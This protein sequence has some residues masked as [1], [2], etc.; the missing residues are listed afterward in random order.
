[1]G[2]TELNKIA[3][4]IIGA[5]IEVH[6]KMGPGL[7]EKVYEECLMVELNFRGIKAERQVEVDLE[8]KGYELSS[9]Y[10]IDILVEDQIILELKA[11]SELNDIHTAQILSYLRLADKRLGYIMN[12][13]EEIMVDGIKRFVNN[14]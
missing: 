11:I 10:L 13:H 6:K 14:F 5:A 1:M 7:F 9:K 4:E 2:Q 12:F 8:Y 3:K